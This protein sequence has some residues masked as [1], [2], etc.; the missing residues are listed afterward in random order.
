L[1]YEEDDIINIIELTVKR[2]IN[3]LYSNLRDCINYIIDGDLREYQILLL[4]SSFKISYQSQHEYDI[5]NNFLFES[6][7]GIASSIADKLILKSY[8]LSNDIKMDC[9]KIGEDF[10]SKN[11]PILLVLDSANL[12]YQTPPQYFVHVTAKH[13]ILAYGYD[14]LKREVYAY[15]T[16]VYDD[17]H[18][19]EAYKVVLSYDELLTSLYTMIAFK[20]DETRIKDEPDLNFKANI[21]EFIFAEPYCGINVFLKSI[22]DL[23]LLYGIK[24]DKGKEIIINLIYI[25]QIKYSIVYEILEG[26]IN[27]SKWPESDKK[28]Y[29]ETNEMLKALWKQLYSKMLLTS[30]L[31]NERSIERIIETGRNVDMEQKK[32]L[33][34]LYSNLVKYD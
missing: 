25:Y 29:F 8:V 11:I 26:V 12:H 1:Q 17:K 7:E 9:I 3:C 33:H 14:S 15:D 34:F 2:G 27:D 31:F 22:E 32:L 13:V 20:K 24:P 10:L 19:E 5:A 28:K 16:Y 6:F 30:C 21:R 4:S 23:Q 18:T